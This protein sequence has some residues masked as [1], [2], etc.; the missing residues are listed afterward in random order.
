M[1]EE[2][3]QRQAPNAL[4]QVAG[5]IEAALMVTD[6]PLSAPKLSELLEGASAKEIK[7]A[8]GQLNELY[9]RTGR[10]FR[11]EQVAGGWQILTLPDYDRIAAA[12]RKTRTVTRL[13][14]A[15]ME[16]LAIVAYKQPVL[17]ADVEAVRGVACGEVLR[18]LMERKL[19]RIVGRA[20]EL[21]RPML[22][23]TTSR[24]LELFGLADLKDLPPVDQ[25]QPRPPPEEAPPEAPPEVPPEVLPEVLPEVPPEVPPEVLAEAPAESV[26]QHSAAK[27]QEDK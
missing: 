24:F 10:S 13:G 22:Y 6:R 27:P 5:Q 23:G 12:L 20:E 17:R 8:V 1:E 14:P 3:D 9:E 2:T 16:T 21:G 19:V 11:I 26:D 7:A 4:P 25:W 18:G 15:A